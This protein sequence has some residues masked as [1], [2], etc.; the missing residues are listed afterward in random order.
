MDYASM[1]TTLPWIL[2][3]ILLVSYLYASVGH[4]GASG[5]LAV[6][7]LFSVA[8][9]EMRPS[10]LVLNCIV[11]LLAFIQ[12]YR[13]GHFL[14]SLFWPFSLVSVPAAFIGGMIHLDEQWYKKI[15]ALVL[16]LAV[17][18]ILMD[19]KTQISS[20][21]MVSPMN[22]NSR[23]GKI[24]LTSLFFG[25]GI[26]LLSGMIGIGGGILLSPLILMLGWADIKTTSGVSA[27]FIFVNSLAGLAG[28][29][30][31]GWECPTQ[32]WFYLPFAMLGGA[33]GAYFG[34]F[35]WDHGVL[36]KMLAIV[37]CIACFKL[38]WSL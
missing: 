20:D 8:P 32:I 11:S 29:A 3:S 31:K 22:A 34:A 12:Y 18:R 16:L 25:M 13:S 1:M 14:W 23:D 33:L 26:G 15:L 35:R 30:T 21:P 4:G 9:N 28:Y 17:Y 7:A 37:L 6:M 10:A 5:Y 38:W 27:L 2:C 36:K 24:L 19:H